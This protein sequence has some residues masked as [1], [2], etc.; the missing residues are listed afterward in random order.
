VSGDDVLPPW[1]ARPV[2]ITP[3]R[4][5]Q[6]VPHDPPHSYGDCFRTAIACLLGVDDPAD[7]PHFV[8]ANINDDD[9]RGWSDLRDARLWLRETY[10]LD[11]FPMERGEADAIGLHYKATVQSPS[12]VPHSVVG[13]R[14]V[15]V[16]CPAGN[17]IIGSS[18]TSTDSAWV[19]ARPWSPDPAEMVA[20]WTAR[21]VKDGAS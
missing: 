4:L 21:V 9:L 5:R 8:A 14:G 12:G 6:I 15:V 16:W 10:D 2:D 17:D 1:H 7:V 3:T 18:I 13:R 19:I 11:L 20:E